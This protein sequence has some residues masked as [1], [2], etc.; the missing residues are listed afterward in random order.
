[1]CVIC[2]VTQLTTLILVRTVEFMCRLIL[3]RLRVIFCWLS[4]P[5]TL[6]T[7]SGGRLTCTVRVAIRMACSVVDVVCLWKDNGNSTV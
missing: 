7:Q 2:F 6:V 4:W 5:F 1:V 3:A